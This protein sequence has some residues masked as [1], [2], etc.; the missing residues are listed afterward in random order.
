MGMTLEIVIP[1]WSGAAFLFSIMAFCI[2]GICVGIIGRAPEL[3][4]GCIIMLLIFDGIAMVCSSG[5]MTTPANDRFCCIEGGKV[6]GNLPT[7]VF[8]TVNPYEQQPIHPLWWGYK[9]F[10]GSSEFISNAIVI[11]KEVV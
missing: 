7:C 8:P 5:Y 4:F 2:V 11:K 1:Y 6:C 9:L 3:I 10:V